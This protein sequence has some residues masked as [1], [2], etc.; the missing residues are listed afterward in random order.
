MPEQYTQIRNLFDNARTLLN[1]DMQ[2]EVGS[3]GTAT[4]K[5]F[6]TQYNDGR[7]EI[8]GS[9]FITAAQSISTGEVLI[10]LSD[11]K[12]FPS[13]IGP[14]THFVISTL[15]TTLKYGGAQY[16]PVT[17]TIVFLSTADIVSLAPAFRYYIRG[18]IV[19]QNVR[20][21]PAYL[22]GG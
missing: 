1:T 4:E 11:T 13:I 17:S 20:A 16:D 18:T 2:N 21:L 8:D 6:Y 22:W 9:F 3:T 5:L 15:D 14:N 12:L 10:D 19:P 7:R